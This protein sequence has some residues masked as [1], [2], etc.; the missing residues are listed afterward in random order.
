MGGFNTGYG[1]LFDTLHGR[2]VGQK[3]TCF[4]LFAYSGVCGRRQVWLLS[5]QVYIGISLFSLFFLFILTF[6]FFHFFALF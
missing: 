4:P 6:S 3:G 1:D 2:S 5:L